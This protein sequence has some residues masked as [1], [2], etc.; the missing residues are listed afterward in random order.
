M[1]VQKPPGIVGG[2]GGDDGDGGGLGGAGG[3]EECDRWRDLV[4]TIW[5]RKSGSNL[6]DALLVPE[7]VS[8]G[9]NGSFAHEQPEQSQAKS[10]VS[11]AQV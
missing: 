4:F 2:R 5:A 7:V 3:C 1:T 6:P 9:G 8:G 11:C 10:D